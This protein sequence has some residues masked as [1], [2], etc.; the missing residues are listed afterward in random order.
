MVWT[1]IVLGLLLCVIVTIFLYYQADIIPLDDWFNFVVEKGDETFHWGNI[2]F[3]SFI[4]E[5][6]A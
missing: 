1:C 2:T 5:V 6:F 3:N 4:E